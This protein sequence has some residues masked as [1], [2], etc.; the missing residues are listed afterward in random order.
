MLSSSLAKWVLVVLE[1]GHCLLEKHDITG[2]TA[3]GGVKYDN[4]QEPHGVNMYKIL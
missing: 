3:C 2:M 1:G 4:E